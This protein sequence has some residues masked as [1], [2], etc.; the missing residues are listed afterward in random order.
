MYCT[1]AK[2]EPPTRRRLRGSLSWFYVLLVIGVTLHCSRGR[3]RFAFT[4]ADHRN[5]AAYEQSVF[6]PQRFVRPETKP[7]FE[8]D[9]VI[10]FAYKP[11]SPKNHSYYA[12]SLQKKSLGYSEIDLRNKMMGDGVGLLIDHYKTLEEGEYRLKIAHSNEVIDQIDFI[13]VG[14]SASES[15]DYEKDEEAEV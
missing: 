8:T 1:D 14:D 12:I 5:L 7:I 11:V 15:I 13:V 2:S 10:W 6:Q 4:V 9:D 3:G